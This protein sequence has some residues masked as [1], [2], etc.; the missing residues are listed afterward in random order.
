M[1]LSTGTLNPKLTTIPDYRGKLLAIVTIEPNQYIGTH[2]IVSP[3]AWARHIAKHG[4]NGLW[5]HSVPILSLYHVA[6]D[7]PYP[8][9]KTYLTASYPELDYRTGRNPGSALVV[10]PSEKQS[11]FSLF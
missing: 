6:I 10:S 2:K 1:I 11:L 7:L 3:A 8:D 4:P 9:A 5:P